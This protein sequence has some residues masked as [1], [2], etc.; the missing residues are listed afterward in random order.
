MAYT[1][2][3]L[4]RG[5]AAYSEVYRSRGEEPPAFDVFAAK[6]RAPAAG[7]APAVSNVAVLAGRY[8]LRHS[9]DP[10]LVG[11]V[12]RQES[13]GQHLRGGRVLTSPAGARG[14]MQLMPG[15]AAGLG[16]D[17]DDLEQNIDGG[18]RY[19]RQQLDTFGGDV[20]KAVAAYNAGPGAVQR[21]NGV[22]PYRETQ[23]YVRNVLAAFR[24]AG[25]GT[26]G[27]GGQISAT[28]PASGAARL[29]VATAQQVPAAAPAMP[30]SAAQQ[31]AYVVQRGDTLSQI[32]Q[33]HGATVQEIAQANGIAD[34]NRIMTGQRLVIPSGPRRPAAAP[35]ARQSGSSPTG[36][37]PII[38]FPSDW[39][40]RPGSVFDQPRHAPAAAAAQAR[41]DDRPDATSSARID[42]QPRTQ[43]FD[44]VLRTPVA[45]LRGGDFLARVAM[46]GTAGA[47][48]M[49]GSAAEG[50][51]RITGNSELERWGGD[52]NRRATT[53]PPDLRGTDALRREAYEVGTQTVTSVVAGA[54][55]IVGGPIGFALN[56]GTIFGLAEGNRSY[57]QAIAEGKPADEATWISIGRGLSEGGSEFV[58]DLIAGKL[59]GV[60]GRAVAPGTYSALQVAGK[61]AIGAGS[62]AASEVGNAF[63]Q[64]IIDQKYGMSSFVP[65]EQW[66]T[67][68]VPKLVRQTVEQTA[69]MAGAGGTIAAVAN[70][71]SSRNEL[72]ADAARRTATNQQQV[73]PAPPAPPAARGAAAVTPPAAPP[74][75]P[76]PDMRT[77]PATPAQRMELQAM[78]H[79]EAAIDGMSQ[80]EAGAVIAGITPAAR[81]VQNQAAATP[82]AQARY[83]G[84]EAQETA[85][86][87]A[88]AVFPEQQPQHQTLST[89]D[90]DSIRGIYDPETLRL[91]REDA[92]ARGDLSF[93]AAIDEHIKASSPDAKPIKPVPVARVFTGLVK[94]MHREALQWARENLQG[95]NARNND[96][97]WDILF[98]RDGIDKTLFRA[99]RGIEFDAVKVLP[100]IVEN[101]IW[102]ETT[103]PRENL[104]HV[105]AFHRFAG[106]II[107][108]G[109]IVPVKITV[110]ETDEGKKFYEQVVV[111]ETKTAARDMY[112]N[113]AKAPLTYR[114]AANQSIPQSGQKSRPFGGERGQIS[115]ELLVPPAVQRAVAAIRDG[116][117]NVRDHVIDVGKRVFVAGKREYFEFMATLRQWLAPVWDKAIKHSR[118]A[119]YAAREWWHEQQRMHAF[120]PGMRPKVAA[121]QQ[122]S[123]NKARELIDSTKDRLEK[124][125]IARLDAESMTTAE[126]EKAIRDVRRKVADSEG[127]IAERIATREARQAEKNSALAKGALAAAPKASARTQA[128]AKALISADRNSRQASGAVAEHLLTTMMEKARQEQQN[129]GLGIE[130]ARKRID[131]ENLG[132]VLND[133]A[134]ATTLEKVA[135]LTAKA[136]RIQQQADQRQEAQ[137]I[138]DDFK[139]TIAKINSGKL[140]AVDPQYQLRI[141]DLLSQFDLQ[142]GFRGLSEAKEHDLRSLLTVISKNGVPFGISKETLRELERL[143]K[144][145]LGEMTHDEMVFLHQ[146][147]KQIMAIGE[148]KKQLRAR[149][150]ERIRQ[151][152]LG[153][154]LS[155]TH[156]MDYLNPDS[157]KL[158]ERWNWIK[159]QAADLT[160]G[161]RYT[162]ALDGGKKY[163]G[164]NTRLL[165]GLGEAVN[166]GE[167]EANTIFVE[168]LDKL[169]AID[170]QLSIDT[171]TPEQRKFWAQIT[172]HMMADNQLWQQAQA[173]INYY[174]LTKA[175]TLTRTPKQQQI[176]EAL[177]GAFNGIGAR[178][179]AVEME[180]HGELFGLNPKY[181]PLKYR[182]YSPYDTKLTG[183]QASFYDRLRESIGQ[184]VPR[185]QTPF[186]GFTY[187]RI[188]GVKKVP[189]I[190]LI[191]VMYEGLGEQLHYVN[192][193]P[194][195]F[196]TKHLVLSEE[197]HQKAGSNAINWWTEQLNIIAQRGRAENYQ[198][199]KIIQWLRG[200]V[201]RAIL[202]Y[203]VTTIALQPT[204]AFDAIALATSMY[205]EKA[206]R[207][208]AAEVALAFSS[209]KATDEFIAKHPDLTLRRGMAGE[210]IMR[211]INTERTSRGEKPSLGG[212]MISFG[213]I[214][215]AA[216]AQR[217]FIRILAQNGAKNPAA[218]AALLMSVANS[219]NNYAYRP[220][221]LSRGD[222]Q[223]ALLMFQSFGLNRA[224]LIFDD[225]LNKGVVQAARNREW[226][227]ALTSLYA[228][229]QMEAGIV[230][231]LV[232]RKG[233]KYGIGAMVGLGLAAVSLDGG[234][235]DDREWMNIENLAKANIST[236]PWFGDIINSAYDAG[237]KGYAR[238]VDNPIARLINNLARGA[239]FMGKVA[240]GEKDQTNRRIA[241]GIIDVM[242]GGAALA[243][244]AG[245]IQAG[246]IA[247]TIVRQ[248]IPKNNNKSSNSRALGQPRIT[249]GGIRGPAIRNR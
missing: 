241:L 224:Q 38:N 168:T 56:G 77:A 62:E 204:A 178:V 136:E 60:I 19:L 54:P 223:K 202:H 115:M 93:A 199:N 12:I 145:S 7:P 114:V 186:S 107:D 37:S 215:T 131:P 230:S 73:P 196:R 63:V 129:V 141:R 103:A 153:K 172:F 209:P 220:Q 31:S 236:V 106:T 24:G 139:K 180:I 157:P 41:V 207:Q 249:G 9:V 91:Q 46:D 48:S 134:R 211:E 163:Q 27:G 119:F 219:T 59:A 99:R 133:V 247:R 23:N 13:G 78:G 194:V 135:D 159:R 65:W 74:A 72:T 198:G 2:E 242:E 4:E 206:G 35:A 125:A 57:K 52:L 88:P 116:V 67:E 80:A 216:G 147:F 69:L 177:R 20:T 166:R 174:D 243:G 226:S 132:K 76:A 201:S 146:N 104:P 1:N 235:D 58:S 212:R 68:V 105:V 22:P 229:G 96:T 53:L 160:F 26:S 16:V 240:F 11:A 102:K 8:A 158:E 10:A 189:R 122:Q 61:F 205:G 90:I 156:N 203:K 148:L 5:Y 101:A 97:G 49:W 87:A 83:T 43:T 152:D 190:D 143:N 181:F 161:L 213:D 94:A 188:P 176:I 170:P 21:H 121:D 113:D 50:V 227:K 85:R 89:E 110:K 128:Q 64:N 175:E 149:Q 200:N 164:E 45:D 15:T 127:K 184:T 231:E 40:T 44:E 155:D 51:G 144:R 123:M 245:T 238:D 6:Y 126:Y 140:K 218:E 193:E 191:G 66:S 18:V 244:V 151:A 17:P 195:L 3:Q 82:P 173:V 185:Q 137:K 111:D 246:E 154:L 92:I 39:A 124:A 55:G 179:R 165:R 210:D 221:I 183:T 222:L 98:S 237:V 187:G 14:V 120:A 29:P 112:A 130:A 71:G 34:P 248:A 225:I 142:A 47:V 28:T 239:F 33:R 117:G 182:D 32:A 233:I 150:V 84:T 217:A 197:Y 100:Q 109:K 79:A 171:E 167:M 30:A 81:T 162:D 108:E 169:K 232:V 95:K 192:T 36:S 42:Q 214:L 86:T 208:V 138:V 25:G 75:P 118:A 228:L 234:D 70:A